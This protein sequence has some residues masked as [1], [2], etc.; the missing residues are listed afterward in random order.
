MDS[1]SVSDSEGGDSDLASGSEGGDSDSVLASEAV[2]STTT[3]AL[4]EDSRPASA[5]RP[6]SRAGFHGF[7][8]G[9]G[10]Q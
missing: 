9:L 2:D 4:L 7:G 6:V 5:S 8:L 10:R 3:L 1:V